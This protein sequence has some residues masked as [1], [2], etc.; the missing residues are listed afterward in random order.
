M[1]RFIT[2]FVIAVCWQATAKS[3]RPNIVLLLID[4]WAWYGSSIPMDEGMSNSRMPIIQMPNLEQ[5]ASEG[6]KFRNAYSGAPQCAPSRVCIQTGQSSARSGFTLVLGKNMPEY[7]DTRKQYRNLPVVPNVSDESIDSDAFTIPEALKP[8]GY[9]SAISANGICIATP[10]RR[11]ISRMMVIPTINREARFEQLKRLPETHDDPK[12]MFSMTAKSVQFMREQVANATPFYLQVSHYANHAF[13]ECRPATREKYIDHPDVQAWYKKN[14]V[15]ADTVNYKQDP[16]VFL[17]M[18]DDLDVCIGSVLDEIK[19]LG[20]E[21]NTYVVVVSD[22]GYRHKFFPGEGQPFHGHKWWVWNGGLRVPMI[23]RGPGIES[24]SKFDA[25]VVHYDFL[26]TFVEW[27]GG[28]P[29][30]LNDIDGVSLAG[31][32]RGKKPDP[33]FVNRNLYFHVPHYRETLP[34]SA[35]VSGTNKVMHFYERPDIPM[36]FDLKTSE[37]EVVNIVR[38]KPKRHEAMLKDLMVYLEKVGGRLPKDNPDYDPEVY[39]NLKNYEQRM[40][41]GPFEGRRPLA[42][43]EK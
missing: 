18:L 7:Y 21:D 4:D 3:E 25:N 33:A 38:Q 8:L 24:G 17:G 5:L 29:Q 42:E 12:L 41:W 36:L 1:N 15:T 6:M 2:L 9:V 11:V 20:I 40:A 26:P 10:V 43:D 32:L 14:R 39:R 35:I 16:A 22:N 31:Y 37:G 34:S 28:D 13:H 23:V 27:A 30:S 19:S